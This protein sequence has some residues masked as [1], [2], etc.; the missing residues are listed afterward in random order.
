VTC[1]PCSGSTC[2][3]SKL[4][5]DSSGDD[6][7]LFDHYDT[8]N[9]LSETLH[10]SEHELR[11]RKFRTVTAK[12]VGQYLS[13]RAVAAGAIDV[14]FRTDDGMFDLYCFENF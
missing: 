14:G 3:A 2:G 1:C 5:R 7:W 13:N 10:G 9:N 12:N 8:N 4:K 6:F 11:K